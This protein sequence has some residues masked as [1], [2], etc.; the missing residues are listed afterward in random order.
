MVVLYLLALV[1]GPPGPHTWRD[2]GLQVPALGLI[3][4]YAIR[5]AVL[6]Q[7]NRRWLV[8]LALWMSCMAVGNLLAYGPER[9]APPTPT[10]LSTLVFTLVGPAAMTTVVRSHRG[11]WRPHGFG[12]M[13]EPIVSTLAIAAVF[14]SFL[15][16]EA[17]AAVDAAGGS[18]RELAAVLVFPLLDLVAVALVTVEIAW[19]GAGA[20][21][22]ISGWLALGLLAFLSA[23]WA[24][25]LGLAR[26]EYTAGGPF[27]GLWV[28]GCAAVGLMAA[29][30]SPTRPSTDTW[31]IAALGVSLISAGAAVSVLAVGTQTHVPLPGVAL[32]VACVAGALVRLLA[33]YVELRELV[34][35]HE[36]ARTDEL[37]GLGNRRHLYG[38]LDARLAG[39]APHA[40]L[41]SDLDAFKPVNDQFG[42]A[43]GD[44]VLVEVADRLRRTMPADS[45]LTRLGGDEFAAVVALTDVTSP[46][47]LAWRFAAAV[48]TI[49]VPGGLVIGASVGFAETTAF[50]GADRGEL[51]RR[52]DAAMYVAKT[53]GTTVHRAGV[54]DD[55]DA[56]YRAVRRNRAAR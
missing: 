11:P 34:G 32:A 40:V 47:E 52:A 33:A 38:E 56:A 20:Q 1:V 45:I 19:S 28:L 10:S 41:I 53:S 8:P 50:P 54:A 26:G 14:T 21:Q 24:F 13:I 43:A 49:A 15:L 2:L 3:A 22:R 12:Q 4:A 17:V 36:L 35:A 39:G 42:H 46:E 9:G 16:P 6:D 30:G 48:E 51:L 55:V 27:D 5:R 23:D 18:P 29:A 37:T 7:D 44:E 25:A 31:G